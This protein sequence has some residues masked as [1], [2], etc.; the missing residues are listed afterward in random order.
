MP[1]KMHKIIGGFFSKKKKKK[2]K[3]IKRNMCEPTLLKIFRPVSRNTLI[4]L[5][6]LVE[7]K[8]PFANRK[9][10]IYSTAR[11]GLSMFNL[12]SGTRIVFLP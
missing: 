5:F 12:F 6:D 1:F 7:E 3:R 10:C 9:I 4:F 8:F 11:Q 2:K